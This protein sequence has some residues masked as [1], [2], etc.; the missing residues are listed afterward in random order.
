MPR[1][2]DPAFHV[3]SLA[4]AVLAAAATCAVSLELVALLYSGK[5][6]GLLGV[7]ILPV[8]FLGAL[9]TAAAF[10]LPMLLILRSL[11]LLN[12]WSTL[13]VGAVLG[14]AT[15]WI[16]HVDDWVFDVVCWTTAGTLAAWAGRSA[17]LWSQHRLAA[18]QLGGEPRRNFMQ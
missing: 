1:E 10:G 12:L 2:T 13:L 16:S 11:G 6:A 7:L 18:K 17:W 15:G 9:I 8:Y 4:L 5:F 3:P 14:A